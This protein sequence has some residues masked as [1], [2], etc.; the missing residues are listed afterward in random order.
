VCAHLFDT[1]DFKKEKANTCVHILGPRAGMWDSVKVGIAGP[2]FETEAGWLMFYHGVSEV[3]HTY[4]IG[5]ALLAKDDL[6]QVLG[7]TSD[8][9]FE[10][11]VVYEKEGIVPNVVFP[12]GTI[13]RDD[14]IY[15]YYGGADTVVGVAKLSLSKLIKTLT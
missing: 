8:A 2:P 3:H 4:R 11:E 13:V 7:R 1:L 15:T 6:S 5:A 10:P 12:C 9:F 14:T